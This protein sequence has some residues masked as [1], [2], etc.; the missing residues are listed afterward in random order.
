[1]VKV[2]FFVCMYLPEEPLDRACVKKGRC[3]VIFCRFSVLQNTS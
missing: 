3:F 1:M 2:L